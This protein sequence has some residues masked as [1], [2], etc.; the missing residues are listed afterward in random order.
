MSLEAPLRFQDSFQKGG[1]HGCSDSHICDG[2][3]GFTH[4][5][6]LDFFDESSPPVLAGLALGR[7]GGVDE[8]ARLYNAT[9][10]SFSLSANLFSALWIADGY[11]A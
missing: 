3:V 2:R 9:I 8:P 7:I 4:Y 5:C 10:P 11:E 6:Q 1:S